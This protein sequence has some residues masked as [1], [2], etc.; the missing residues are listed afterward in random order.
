V[1]AR[2]GSAIADPFTHSADSVEILRRRARQV[3]GARSPRRRLALLR[4]AS[5]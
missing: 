5:V 1:S 2:D 3:T 4:T